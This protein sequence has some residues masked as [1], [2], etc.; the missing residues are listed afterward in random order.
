M[1]LFWSLRASVPATPAIFSSTSASVRSLRRCL[2]AALE[3]REQL[4]VDGVLVGRGH[5]VRRSRDDFQRGA[6]DQ[7]AR[8]QSC[9]SDGH[10]LVV[11]S[12]KDQRRYVHLFQVLGKIRFR[13][14]FDA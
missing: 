11:V 6:R 3:K 13:K 2:T 9:I 7:L 4:G 8:K 12:M 10:N 5:A 14:R 1:T